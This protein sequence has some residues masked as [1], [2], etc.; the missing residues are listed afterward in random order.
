MKRRLTALIATAAVAALALSACSGGGSGDPL[1]NGSNGGGDSSSA[2]KVGSAD[3]PESTL[4]AEVY[5]G[6]LEAKG[7]KVDR[8]LGI[9]N[10]ELYLRALQDGSIDLIPEYAAGLLFGVDKAAP[11][12]QTT[13][14]VDALKTKLPQGLS[15]LAASKAEDKDALVVTR[16]TADKYHLAK[17]SDLAAVAG[18]LTMG[19][20]DEWKVRPQGLA[21]YEKTYG[22]TFKDVVTLDSGG[23]LTVNGL[24]AGQVQVANLY[25]TDPALKANDFVVLEDD[26]HLQAA[27]NV[28][29][30]VRTDRVSDDARTVLNKVSEKLTTDDLIDMNSRVNG[31]EDASTVAADWLKKH[32]LA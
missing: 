26:K 10:R 8:Q 13:E 27:Q 16:E 29:P 11:Q 24:K 1:N 23:P 14:I 4:I 12:T 6:A 9:G 28:L 25:T 22:I 19:A 30:L 31:G 20:A 15:V 17:V 3:F 7:V 21:G 18:E 5:A 32:G 2:I